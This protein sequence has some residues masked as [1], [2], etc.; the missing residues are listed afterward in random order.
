MG[1]FYDRERPTQLLREIQQLLPSCKRSNIDWEEFVKLAMFS[2]STVSAF[3]IM[4]RNNSAMLYF[5][6]DVDS[7]TP[8]NPI[9]TGI[10]F[11]YAPSKK[12]KS[13]L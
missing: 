10:Y 3:R 4:A 7:L 8:A 13:W 9:A 12:D 6:L 1:F 11:C 5:S 2:N